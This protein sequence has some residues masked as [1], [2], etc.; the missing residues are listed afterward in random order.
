VETKVVIV[1]PPTLVEDVD[2]L[3][4]LYVR[5]LD[6]DP[7]ATRCLVETSIL[8]HGIRCVREGLDK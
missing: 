3:T 6:G 7:A 5:K 4:E 2:A 8:Q 1:V